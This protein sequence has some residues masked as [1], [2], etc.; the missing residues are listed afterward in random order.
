MVFGLIFIPADRFQQHGSSITFILSGFISHDTCVSNFALII[1]V[2]L[3]LHAL[4]AR[5]QSL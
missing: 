1:F 2:I 3:N 5:C 4:A